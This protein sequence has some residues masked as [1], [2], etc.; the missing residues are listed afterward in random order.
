ML[1][2]VY[3]CVCIYNVTHSRWCEVRAEEGDKR[4]ERH[5]RKNVKHVVKAHAESRENCLAGKEEQ[6]P[7]KG[8]PQ[9]LH[10]GYLALATE[11]RRGPA[12]E[13]EGRREV[14]PQEVEDVVRLDEAP[15]R[16]GLVRQVDDGVVKDHAQQTPRTDDVNA[17]D[18]PLF[19]L[20]LLRT[21]VCVYVNN[22]LWCL[23]DD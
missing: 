6:K 21:G 11:R 12:E 16:P 22:V 20:L 2:C 13:Q 5:T 23:V 14:H 7:D 17:Q 9:A 10:K 8:A 19:L 3:V 1:M 15:V 4:T 18:A